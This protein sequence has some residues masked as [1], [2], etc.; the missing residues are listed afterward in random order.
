[1]LVGVVGVDGGGGLGGGGGVVADL[2][3]GGGEG[4]AVGLFVVVG[5]GYGLVF[6]VGVDGFD[7]FFE[8]EMVLDLGYA[9]FA[10]HFGF[11]LE[12]CVGVLRYGG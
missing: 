3:E 6:Q 1:M 4:F 7:A 9:V 2:G 10:D 12:G 5:D 8:A 11:N